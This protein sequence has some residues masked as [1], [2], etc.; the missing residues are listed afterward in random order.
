M[1]IVMRKTSELVPYERTIRASKCKVVPVPVP[2]AQDFFIRNH[3]QTAPLVTTQ[4]VM[5][6]LDYRGELVAV[7]MYDR[8]AG[9]VRG[10]KGDFE[11]MRLSISKNT[12]VHGGASKL[13]KACEEALREKGET[14]I[15][16]YSNATI[17][18]GKVYEALGFHAG[19]IDEGQ[20]HVILRNNAL[21]RLINLYPKTTNGELAIRGWTKTFIG[22]NKMWTKDI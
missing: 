16:S 17:N 13:Q 20:P 3:R 5:L 14:R 8:S 21:V 15:F 2:M 22:G 11:L 12:Q 1:Q 10:A 4:A 9:A 6:G 19:K 18:N 7:M